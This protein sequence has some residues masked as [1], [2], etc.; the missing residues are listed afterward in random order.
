MPQITL[1]THLSDTC[2]TFI[3]NIFTNFEKN[4]TNCILTR[5]ISDHQMTCCMLRN[6]NV[7]NP[8]N[9]NYIEV[10]NLNEKKTLGRFKNALTSTQIHEKINHEVC[11]SEQKLSNLDQYII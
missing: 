8:V 9:R 6:Y 11:Q 7:I 1:A 3:G 10:E 2:N 4:H 5:T